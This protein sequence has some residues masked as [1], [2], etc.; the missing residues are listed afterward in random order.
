MERAGQGEGSILIT[1]RN[2]WLRGERGD[3]LVSQQ[4]VKAKGQ[5]FSP[6]GGWSDLAGEPRE[7]GPHTLSQ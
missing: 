4:R 5:R 2:F 7:G 3:R 1:D 6:G